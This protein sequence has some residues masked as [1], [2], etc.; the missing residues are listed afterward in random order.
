MLDP[1]PFPS[2]RAVVLQPSS[3]KRAMPTVVLLLPAELAR[4]TPAAHVR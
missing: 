3:W 4:P 1:S 2:R